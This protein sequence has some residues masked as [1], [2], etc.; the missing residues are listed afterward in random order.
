MNNTHL[1]FLIITGFMVFT[2]FYSCDSSSSGGGSGELISSFNS[3]RSHNTGSN[4]MNCH[5]Q[6]GGGDGIFSVAGTVY[7][8]ALNSVLPNSIVRIYS[9]PNSDEMPIAVIEVDS[10]GNFYTTAN[11]NFGDGLYTSVEGATTEI[12]MESPITSG[13]CSSCHGDST[14]RVWAK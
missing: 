8:E 1:I 3:S 6:G 4:C 2:L 5:V 10:R 9:S 14:E 13:S 11:I 12:F 7:D